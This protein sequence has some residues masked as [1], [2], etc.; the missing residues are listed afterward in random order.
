M[1]RLLLNRPVLF[2]AV[3]TLALGLLGAVG[4]VGSRYGPQLVP[5]GPL[6][7]AYGASLGLFFA[8]AFFLLRRAPESQWRAKVVGLFG[9]VLILGLF[10]LLAR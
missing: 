1:I 5:G 8:A 7:F 3:V 10:L 4:L 6:G 2:F 9:A